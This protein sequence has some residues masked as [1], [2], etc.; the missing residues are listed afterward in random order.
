MESL[1]HL[2]YYTGIMNR[3][4]DID[5]ELLGTSQNIPMSVSN[6][7]PQVENASSTKGKRGTNFN[8]AKGLALAVHYSI[9]GYDYTIGYYLADGIYPKWATFVKTIPTPQGQK[10]K[11]FAA[12][13]EAYRKDVECAFGVFQ[14]RFAI[15]RG[16]ARFFHLKTLQKIMKACII[17]HNM[18]V[19]DER[20][21]NEV[22]DLDYEQ[23]DGM[24][25][26]PI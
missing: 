19:E 7:P 16:L 6:S 1:R 12:T 11:L 14:A 10:Q 24:D 20:D 4:I 2:P 22:V 8:L 3:D 15:V 25:N 13:Q 23:I 18:I 21:D 26:P 17:L 9:N 5:S